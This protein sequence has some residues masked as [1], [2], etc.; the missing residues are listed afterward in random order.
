MQIKTPFKQQNGFTL[1]EIVI[2]IIL[3]SIFGLFS[4][5]RLLSLRIAAEKSS[6]I[7]VIGNIKS[8]LGLEVVRL[9]L[10]GKMKEIAE[11]ENTNPFSLLAQ[12]PTNYLGETES[13]TF[14]KAGSWYFDKSKGMLIYN[15]TYTE[16]FESSLKEKNLP[17]IRHQ[18]KLVYNDNNDNKRFDPKTDGIGGLDLLPTE[19]YHWKT[20]TNFN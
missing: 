12:I 16:Y 1:L 8:S 2:V 4:V 20:P 9:A 13:D 6:V 19:K 15:V 18:I 3:I 17:Q 14:T 5:D 11:L 7:Q 10:Q